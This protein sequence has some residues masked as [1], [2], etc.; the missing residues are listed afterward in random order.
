MQ[1]I[2]FKIC[3]AN[4]CSV[5]IT[6]SFSWSW[7]PLPL[8]SECTGL[9]GQ[10]GIENGYNNVRN[11]TAVNFKHLLYRLVLSV[12]P[13][14]TDMAFLRAW[15]ENRGRLFL[16]G[17]VT[18]NFLEDNVISIFRIVRSYISH[19]CNTKLNRMGKLAFV[20]TS[21]KNNV[22]NEVS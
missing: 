18:Q 16:G 13:I 9:S 20:W 22:M 14:L 1:V 17:C 5:P 8:Q 3:L 6:L 15:R 12:L 7:V 10:V 2:I 19:H 4:Q 21:A 11:N